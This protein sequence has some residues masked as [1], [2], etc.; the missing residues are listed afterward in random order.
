MRNRLITKISLGLKGLMILAIYNSDIL[1]ADLP[2]LIT[3]STKVLVV[4]TIHG[5]HETNPNYSYQDLLNILHTYKPDAICVEIR[6]EDFRKQSYLK[7]M[8]MAT[9]FGIDQNI[10]VY[11]IDWWGTGDDRSKQSAYIKTPEY[12]EKE[13]KEEELVAANSVMQEFDKKYVNLKTLWNEN[14]KGY[15]FF[16]GDEYNNYIREMYGISMTV[17]GDGPMNLSYQTRNGKMLEFIENA[18][19]ENV[20]KR[21]IVLTGAEHKHYFD[22]AL[23][24][25]SNVKLMN[26]KDIL[27]LQSVSPDSNIVSFLRDNLAKGYFDD[28]TPEGIDQ[29]YSGALVPLI[30]G[31]GM[32]NDPNIVPINNLPKAKQLIDKWSS[33]RPNSSLLQFEISWVYFLYSDYKKAAMHLEKIHDRLDEIPVTKQSFVKPFFYRN[34]GFCY[35]MIGKHKKAIKC[36]NDG[37]AAC[38]K[39]GFSESYIKSIFKDYRKHPYRGLVQKL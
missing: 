18:L 15:E 21:V 25:N 34:L 9:I 4:A 33:L 2:D 6:P 30:H 17:Y 11:P 35:D 22:L 38:K 5:N 19:K 20:G 16:N 8:M 37:E 1:A 31:M 29:L 32:D 36:Y 12:K 23:A 10:K 14:K 13:K 39:L 3:D 26:I 27:P 24:T 7:E 28:S